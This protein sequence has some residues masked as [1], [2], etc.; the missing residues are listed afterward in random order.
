MNITVI[1]SGYVGLVSA[2]C[3]ADLGNHVT[4]VDQ[5]KA[6]IRSLH[7]GKI[8][9]HEPG[10]AHMVSKNISSNNLLFT[11]SYRQAISFSNVIF[12]CVGT[13]QYNNG[14][15]NLKYLISC[16]DTII[17]HYKKENI[18]KPLHIFIKSTIAP[19]TINRINKKIN[20]HGL[21]QKLLVSSN[22]EFL[23]EGDAIND[24]LKP[25]RIV[26]GSNNAES[27]KIA[28]SLYRPI[29]WKSNRVQVVSPE[30]AEIIKYA[31]N[32][33]LATKISFINEIARLSDAVGADIEEIRKGIGADERINPNF[34]Y[35]GLGFGGSCFPKD[36]SGLA[37][38]LK[39]F[40]IESKLANATLQANKEQINYFVKKIQSYYGK[41]LKDMQLAIWGLSFK[42]NT[43]DIRESKAIELIRRLSLKTKSL[44][45]YDPI[46]IKNAK[47]ELK[48]IPNIKFHKSAKSTLRNSDG[49]ILCTEWKEFWSP[50]LK[51]LSLLKKK[52]IFDGRNIMDKDFLIQNGFKYFGIGK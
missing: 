42:P 47:N 8:P 23:K 34:L 33:F 9:F 18:D 36:V 49:L 29:C 37:H 28:E 6:K 19:G 46:A 12:I 4:C 45:L 51:D 48:N 14:R 31:S 35:A 7:I 21:A 44:M 1:G 15:P 25:D 41:N 24:F 39:E 17:K 30:S 43:D 3:F 5:D 13:P 38:T 22:P 27:I 26:I 52:V 32:A 40:R 10:L 2:A 50:P 16:I 11:H 20:Y